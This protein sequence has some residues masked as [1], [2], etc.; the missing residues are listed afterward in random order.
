MMHITSSAGKSAPRPA[1]SNHWRLVL[2]LAVAVGLGAGGLGCGRKKESAS[3]SAPGEPAGERYPL[4]GEVIAVAIDRQRAVIKHDP[5][6]GYM[7]AMT[8]EFIVSPG[9]LAVMKPG[10]RIKADLIPSENDDFRLE[11]IWPADPATTGAL[12]AG[13][14]ALVQDTTIR[15]KRAY[16]EVG[17]NVPDFTLLNQDSQ[18]VTAAR[19]RG[20][21]IL[22]NF[23]FTRC[24]VA[25]MCPA[26]VARF[27][28]VQQK[29]K[30]QGVQNLEL[31]SISLDPEFDTPGVLKDYVTARGIDTSNY[32]FL[33]GP[34][35]AIKALL[36]QFGVLKETKGDLINHT[37]ATVLVD[38]TGRIRWRV[39]GSAW[40]VEE[41]VGRMKN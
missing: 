38:E 27:Q 14:N 2:L 15:A 35:Q 40:T 23:I 11:R 22:V 9:D 8:M 20:K 3:G 16:R 33:T 10:Q 39:D 6:P 4:T 13:A 1:V 37:L 5:I 32:S 19:F 25:T 31:V 12:A 18:V 7:P 26:A 34:E 36:V 17:E 28:Q 21:L 24:P 30:E 41:F 29:A